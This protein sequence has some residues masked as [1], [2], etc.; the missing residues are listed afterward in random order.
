MVADT[1]RGVQDPPGE[2]VDRV[3]ALIRKRLGAVR[4]TQCLA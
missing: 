2:H 3:E 4:V 1:A